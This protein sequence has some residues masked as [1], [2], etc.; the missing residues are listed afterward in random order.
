MYIRKEGISER[1]TEERT[2]LAEKEE[3]QHLTRA[4]KNW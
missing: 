4:A 2:Q 3:L 1:E